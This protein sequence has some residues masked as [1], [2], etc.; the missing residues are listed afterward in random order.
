MFLYDRVMPNGAQAKYHKAVKFY[1]EED[2]THA[3]VNSY[4][5]EELD[6]ISW[7]DT[8]VIPLAVKIETLA[9]VEYLLTY[10]AA[11][12]EGGAIVPDETATLDA[13]KARK[14][15]ELSLR[16]TKAE[17]GG[18]VTPLGR[19]QTDPDSRIKILGL[20][21]MASAAKSGGDTSWPQAFTMEDNSEVAHD[22][23]QM[24]ALSL[25]VGAYIVA[26]HA[27][28]ITLKGTI[29]ACT[30]PEE[31]DAVDIETGWPS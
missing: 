15:G 5:N 31:V 26:C 19:V 3:V 29:M 11:P 22:A 24:M 2:G 9:D 14:K 8:Y 4:H 1:V 23:D 10:S 21:V 27:N 30:T 25:A 17:N 20:F 7:Q 16:Q 18:C 6:I 13:K 28:A 12:F